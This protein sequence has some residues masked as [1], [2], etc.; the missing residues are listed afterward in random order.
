[1]E[2]FSLDNLL[3]PDFKLTD[4]Q[5]YED[6]KITEQNHTGSRYVMVLTYTGEIPDNCPSCGQ[7][8]NLHGTRDILVTDTTFNG[9]PNKLQLIVP[10]K[11][12]RNCG[13]TWTPEL[14]SVDENHRM[15]SRAYAKFANLALKRSFN[16]IAEEYGVS[17]KTAQRI[18]V[19][20]IKEKE[21]QLRFKT[22]AFLGLDEIK[23]KKLGEVT[24]ITDLEHK[25]LYDMMLGRTQPSLTAYFSEMPDPEDVLWVCTDMYRPFEKS[26]KTALPN[27]KWVVDH[28]HIVAYA[29]RAIDAVRIEV[30][31]KLS[32][33]DRIK[34]KKGLAYTLRTRLKKLSAEDASKIRACRDDEIYGPLAVAYDLKEDFFNIYDE[35]L[36]SKSDAQEAFETWEKSIPEDEIYKEFRK[37]AK[38][39]HNFYEQIFNF[40][41]CPI[42]ITNGFTECS[43]RI[44]R[45]NNVRGRGNSF[46]ILRGRTLYRRA[47]LEKIEENAMLLGPAVATKGPLFHYEE[48]KGLRDDES[49]QEDI[50]FNS[51]DYDPTIGLIPGV[52]FDPETGEIFDETLFD[53][54][55]LEYEQED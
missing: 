33:E 18:F 54:G 34:T 25:T 31:K 13:T 37:L 28:Y 9:A 10:R 42:T 2:N 36:N 17:N 46:E 50:S 1:M 49:L 41:D 53:E 4:I 14:T 24:V 51:F 55:Y 15:T 44:I 45:E 7:S 30:Q 16:D 23:I 48:V 29:N 5:K 47:N 32:S 52:N 38:T 11:Y 43:N 27:A 26:I 12:C 39:V 8:M 22:P 6:A 3:M 40:W 21:R 20:F 19:E 35:H